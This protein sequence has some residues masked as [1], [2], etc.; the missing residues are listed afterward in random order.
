MCDPVTLGV[1]ALAIAAGGGM[2]YSGVEGAKSSKK[3]TIA[4]REQEALNAKALAERQNKQAN[5]DSQRKYALNLMQQKAK[6]L[7]TQDDSIFGG[8]LGKKKALLGG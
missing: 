7:G 8:F 2:A 1:S 6:A 4:R 3:A 5:F